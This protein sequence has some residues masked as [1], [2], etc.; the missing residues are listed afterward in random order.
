ML[1][2]VWLAGRCR[3]CLTRMSRHLAGGIYTWSHSGV[4]TKGDFEQQLKQL[5]NLLYVDVLRPLATPFA[6]HF[7]SSGQQF[8]GSLCLLCVYSFFLQCACLM[9][10]AWT[11]HWQRRAICFPTL[12]SFVRYASLLTLMGSASTTLRNAICFTGTRSFVFLQASLKITSCNH[13]AKQYYHNKQ[14]KR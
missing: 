8:K 14:H 13:R 1:R 9:S 2:W 12:S 10:S 3:R 5:D 11:I 6:T 4:D 7:P